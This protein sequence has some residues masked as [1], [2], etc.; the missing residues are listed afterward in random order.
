MK[1][2]KRKVLCPRAK[3]F[4]CPQIFSF[5]LEAKD[6]ENIHTKLG[7]KDVQNSN[8]ATDSDGSKTCH[9]V[10]PRC[11]VPDCRH[12]ISEMHMSEADITRHLSQHAAGYFK[13]LQPYP[14]M[15]TDELKPK[16]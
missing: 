11:T 8:I 1:K 12:T 7:S 13:N 15:A 3:Q 5:V 14:P 16:K 6:H 2:D 9:E 10:L 4:A